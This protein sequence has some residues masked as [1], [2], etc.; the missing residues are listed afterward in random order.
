MLEKRGAVMTFWKRAL[1]TL[2]AMLV[3]SLLVGLIWR[4][5]F[6]VRIPSYLSG[7]VGGLA[8]VFTW[9]TLRSAK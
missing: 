4:V 7:L 9:E 2:I 6:D 5:T 1:F 3:A 8:A